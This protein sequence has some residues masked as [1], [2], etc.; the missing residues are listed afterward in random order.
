M[1]V[2][3]DIVTTL[4]LGRPEQSWLPAL[5]SELLEVPLRYQLAKHQKA[6]LHTNLGV[7]SVFL[8]KHNPLCIHQNIIN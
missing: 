1:N 3:S 5:Q 8:Y 4:H 7:R 6:D 2:L